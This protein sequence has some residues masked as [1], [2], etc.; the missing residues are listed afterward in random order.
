MQH[1]TKAVLKRKF[2][3]V[4]VYIRKE[5]R[6]QLGDLSS[7]LKESEKEEQIRTKASRMKKIMKISMESNE[8]KTKTIEKKIN[9]V[10]I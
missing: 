7:Y 8:I 6:S 10:K 3:A 9:E 4:N 2:I 1:A 5:K